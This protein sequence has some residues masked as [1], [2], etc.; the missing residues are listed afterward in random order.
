MRISDDHPLRRHFTA[1]VQNAFCAEVGMCDPALTDYL[2]ELLVNF[3]HIDYLNTIR[4]AQGRELDQIAT[5]LLVVSGR[6]PTT[7]AE[8]DQTVYR[9][10]GDYTLFWAGSTPSSCGSGLIAPPTSCLTTW[11]GASARMP[12]YPSWPRKRMPRRHRSSAT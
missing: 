5:M 9:Q 6:S 3:T 2:A 8:R 10:I 7:E 1:L 12:S 11:Y 4:N